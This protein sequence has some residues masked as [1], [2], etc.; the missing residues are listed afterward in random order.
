MSTSLA[1]RIEI[2]M[3]A[4]QFEKC[5]GSQ[6]CASRWI[7]THIHGIPFCPQLRCCSSVRC[8]SCSCRRSSDSGHR[9]S[10]WMRII[11]STDRKWWATSTITIANRNFRSARCAGA[12]A[13]RIPIA[14]PMS[15]C[16]TRTSAMAT[17]TSSEPRAI[18]PF[19]VNCLWW[20]TARP[21]STK[22]PASEVS[23]SPAKPPEVAVIRL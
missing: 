11:G 17:R 4:R 7:E 18:W 9:W 13:T 2:H 23:N 22:R 10:I 1:T 16:W 14:L 8:T 19:R 15:I 21:S 20:Q 6:S 3:T 5:V 12:S